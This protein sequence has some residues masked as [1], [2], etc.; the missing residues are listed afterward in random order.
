MNGVLYAEDPLLW[1]AGFRSV[2]QN[3]QEI[4]TVWTVREIK[5]DG[6]KGK[7]VALATCY[8]PGNDPD[9]RPNSKEYEEILAK[10]PK[11]QQDFRKEVSR[12]GRAPETS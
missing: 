3:L 10:L 2:L 4:G 6:V 12:T 9:D 7:L 11:E 5:A 1:E 8:T